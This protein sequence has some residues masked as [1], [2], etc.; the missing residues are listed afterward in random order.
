M[1]KAAQDA[2][3]Q[4]SALDALGTI[5]KI[6]E[7]NEVLERENKRLLGKVRSQGAAKTRLRRK[8]AQS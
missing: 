1:S 5:Q 2:L 8:L 6:V 4:I 7:R 3:V